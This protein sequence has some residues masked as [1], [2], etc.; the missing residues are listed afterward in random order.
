MTIDRKRPIT[1]HTRQKEIIHDIYRYRFLNRIHIQRFLHHKKFNRIITWLNLLTTSG[2]LKRYYNPKLVTKPAFYSLGPQGR[3]YLRE[4]REFPDV[5]QSLLDRIWQEYKASGQFKQRCMTIAEYVFSPSEFW[6]KKRTQHSF[7][8]LKLILQ[9]CTTLSFHLRTRFSPLKSTPEVHEAIF[10]ISL[11]IIQPEK[12]SLIASN[13][14]F[15]TTRGTTGRITQK[16]RSRI[17][18]LCARMPGPFG[19]SPGEFNISWKTL[20]HSIF[21]LQHRIS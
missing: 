12:N 16:I 9:E 20:I 6:S 18:S 5:K 3:I 13:V 1:L 7:L 17:L 10:L 19:T 21:I 14:I 15:P 2:Y 4:S 11:M 8:K